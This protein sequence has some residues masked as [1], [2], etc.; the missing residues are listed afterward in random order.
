MNK[1]VLFLFF[2]IHQ[3]L[4]AQFFS[5]PD[6]SVSDKKLIED[7]AEL[8]PKFKDKTIN[9]LADFINIS[10]QNN[11]ETNEKSVEI[12]TNVFSALKTADSQDQMNSVSNSLFEKALKNSRLEKRLDL[13]I[14]VSL[15]Y[16]FYFYTYRK[17]EKSFPLFMFCVKNLDTTEDFK[18]IQISDT[19]KKIAYFLT[20]TDEFSKAEEYL[21]KAQKYAKPESSELASILNALGFCSAENNKLTEA[22]NYY[23][24]TLAVA[25]KSNDEVRYAKALGSIAEL[26]IKKK[27]YSKAIALL[28]KDIA[29]SE[30]E[31][32]NQN[33]MYALTVLSKAYLEKGNVD[34]AEKHLQLAQNYAQSKSY[35]KSSEFQINELI[36]KIAEIKGDDATELMAR[37]RLEKLKD[38]LKDFDGK[39]TILKIGWESQKKQLQLKVEI[40]KAKHQ[41]ESYLK[42][43]AIIIC[44]LLALIIIALIRSYRHKMRSKKS[45]YE[46]KVLNLLVDKIK[47]ENKLN[48]TNKTINSY[49]TYLAEKNKQIEQLEIEMEN[50][51]HSSSSFLEEKSGELQKLLESHLMTDENW[52]NFRNAFIQRYPL[53]YKDLAQQYP[54]LTESNMRIIILTKLLMSNSEISRLLGVTLEA[55]KKAKQRLRKKYGDSSDQLFEAIT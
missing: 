24:Q 50:V 16:G 13:E 30:S 22:E 31:G 47:S 42:I 38:S 12:I 44:I 15:N 26:E 52:K 35:F 32:N 37:R 20:T 18:I 29:I 51:K 3:F 19:Y 45:E 39:E 11:N 46:T 49:R 34:Q 1:P 5:A 48:S 2:L 14:W 54:D 41:K 10:A 7:I 40:E 27:N 23:R 9:E 33:T 21:K 55:V 28:E 6:Y 36:L 4:G 8:Y 25:K 53:Q 43:T 17:Y